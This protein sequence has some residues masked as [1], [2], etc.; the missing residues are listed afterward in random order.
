MVC[1]AFFSLLFN[2]LFSLLPKHQLHLFETRKELLV[3][4]KG[5]EELIKQQAQLLKDIVETINVGGQV[6]EEL[7]EH[8]R[9]RQEIDKKQEKGIEKKL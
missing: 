7:Y 9:G 6:S 4:V 2:L 1:F 8:I 3:L 5:H